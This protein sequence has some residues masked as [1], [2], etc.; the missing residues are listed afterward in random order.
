MGGWMRSR[1]SDTILGNIIQLYYGKVDSISIDRAIRKKSDR[2]FH[3][4]RARSLSIPTLSIPKRASDRPFH[5]KRAID[6]L[7]NSQDNH[8]EFLVSVDVALRKYLQ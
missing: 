1:R 7:P 3:D 2:P 5:P 4:K 6:L 8:S